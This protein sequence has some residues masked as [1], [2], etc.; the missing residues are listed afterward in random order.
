MSVYALFEYAKIFPNIEY[1]YIDDPNNTGSIQSRH[2]R[3][4]RYRIINKYLY[5]QYKG[6]RC[7][8]ISLY[9]HYISFHVT[10]YKNTVFLCYL[11][12]DVTHA[13]YKLGRI[14]I[15][16][17]VTPVFKGNIYY[18]VLFIYISLIVIKYIF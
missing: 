8:S 3:I 2:D 6:Q 18:Y 4:M 9:G 10:K 7:K 17:P 12:G 5:N 15:I 13:V 14:N 16:W 11:Y 1:G